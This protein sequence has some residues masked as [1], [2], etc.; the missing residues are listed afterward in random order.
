MEKYCG[1]IDKCVCIVVKIK[2][3]NS[4]RISDICDKVN[5][6]TKLYIFYNTLLQFFT[7]FY[8]NTHKYYNFLHI[9]RNVP[10]AEPKNFPRF[11]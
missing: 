6:T 10:T 1:S 9:R 3:V 7:I 2:C 5:F 4:D 8:Q 11:E